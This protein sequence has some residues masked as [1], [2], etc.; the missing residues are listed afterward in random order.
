MLSPR[1]TK[2]SSLREF[3]MKPLS[4]IAIY[5]HALVIYAL[6]FYSASLFAKTDSQTFDVVLG[7]TLTVRTDAGSID[8]S[9]HDEAVI[10]LEV[11]VENREGDTF[12]YR[13]ELTNG[14]LT[15]IGEIEDNNNWVR[16][17][18]V[19]FKLRIPVDYNVILDTSG[20]SLSIEDLKGHVNART[21]GGSISVGNVVGDVNLNTSGGSIN[22]DTITGNL[23]AHT[24]GGSINITVNKQLTEDAKLTT[25]GGSITA[26]LME[27]IQIELDAS[28]SG[29]RVKSDFSVAGRVKKHSVKGLINGG[30]PKLTLTTSGGGVRI[31]SL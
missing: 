9:T 21:S 2:H 6:L 17:L 5:L 24:S 7:G 14:N 10:R 26:Y 30:G 27:K 4:R 16:N 25:S 20:G 22:T 29:G 12:T 11:S 15:V 28:T 8:I 31:K 18:K 23:N 3:K 1:H 13:H 19:E